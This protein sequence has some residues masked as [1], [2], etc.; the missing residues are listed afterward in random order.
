MLAV[1]LARLS[2][3]LPYACD[4]HLVEPRPVPG[5]GLAYTARRPEYLLNVRSQFLSAFPDQPDHFQNW[6]RLTSP[7]ICD[8]GFCSRQSYGRYLQQLVSQ[9][10][11]WPATNGMRFQW[12]NQA[13]RAVTVAAD[14]T[15]ATVSLNNGTNVTSDFVVL[16]LGNFP[17]PPPVRH[18]TE[19][20]QHHTYHGNP[21][22]QGALRNIGTHDSVLLIGTGLTAV[23]VL[24]GLRADGHQGPVTTVSG[25]GRWPA[26]HQLQS[27]SYPDFYAADLHGADTV[28][29]VLQVVRRHIRLAQAQGLNWRAVL[30][31][32]RPHLGAIWMGWP[33][34]EQA[35]FLRHLAGMW[36]VARHRS[37]PQN[38]VL[39]EE[40]FLSGQVRQETGRVRNIEPLA[41]ELRVTVQHGMQPPRQLVAR[42]VITC[43]GPLLDYNRIQ[44]P[45][46]AELRASGHLQPDTLRLGIQTDPHGALLNTAGAPSEVLFT[47]GPSRRPAFFESTAV[48]ELREQAVALAQELGQRLRTAQP[49]A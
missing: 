12:H 2:G 36:S 13:A 1:Q 39:L 24:L 20:L 8:Q 44:E 47:L 29:A 11:E 18:T 40:M 19:Y 33:L 48:P 41:E 42:H 17:P 28:L 22:A 34:A 21:W 5:P 7:E 35:R 4:V 49:S 16:A 27:A 43:T 26:A 31:V 38:M 6:L 3:G 46:V 9:V 37:P 30:D 25:H 14:G 23:D 10:L 45:L 15:S 32:L